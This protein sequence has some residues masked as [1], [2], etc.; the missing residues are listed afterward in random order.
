MDKWLLI[1]LFVFIIIFF[2]KV[3][4]RKK[5]NVYIEYNL[6]NG[7]KWGPK[8]TADTYRFGDIF[9]GYIY[10]EENEGGKHQNARYIDDISINYP[11]TFGSKYIEYNGY[12]EK[13]KKSDYNILERIFD[14]SNFEKQDDKTLVIHLRLGDI[15]NPNV[16][17]LTNYYYDIEYYNELLKTIKKNSDIK[18]VEIVTGLH[19]DIYIKES[20]DRLNDVRNIFESEYPV[21]V[22]ITN[23]PDKDLYYMCHSKYFVKSGKMGG[24]SQIV[25]NYVE[26]KNNVVYQNE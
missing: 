8:K 4:K 23:D 14:E 22:I 1:I 12:P 16:P 5:K 7:S 20:N 26:K 2:Y 11:N 6:Y 10:E 19:K 15:F 24:F 9:S 25:A 3:F 21:N 13:Y 18:K 17:H